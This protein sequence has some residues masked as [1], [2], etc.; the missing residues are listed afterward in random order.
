MTA[1]PIVL[2]DPRG[3][4]FPYLIPGSTAP[5]AMT[6]LA[7][8]PESGSSLSLVRFPPGWQRPERGHYDVGEEFLVVDGELAV[9]ETVYAPGELAWIPAG[10][11]RFASSTHVEAVALAWFSGTPRWT[12]DDGD[13]ARGPS[14]RVNVPTVVLPDHGPLVLRGGRPG[15]AEGT[16]ALFACA[17]AV[18]ASLLRGGTTLTDVTTWRWCPAESPD[19]RPDW[20]GRVLVRVR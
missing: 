1:P 4:A 15:E 7:L 9:S 17:A 5:V 18:P 13:H 12:A 10:T 8:D 3:D 2:S 14:T 19:A 11:L 20:P 6:R 16:T